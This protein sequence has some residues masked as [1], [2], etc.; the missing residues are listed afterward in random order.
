V[1]GDS[2]IDVIYV[3]SLF[4]DSREFLHLALKLGV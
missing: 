1:P 3:S 4:C 2:K